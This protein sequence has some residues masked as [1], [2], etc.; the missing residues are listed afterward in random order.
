MLPMHGR[1]QRTQL[2]LT[3]QVPKW[4]TDTT[5]CHYPDSD[6]ITAIIGHRATHANT[7]PRHGLL[8]AL[9]QATVIKQREVLHT[10]ETAR[11][12]R[13]QLLHTAMTARALI[14]YLPSITH[15]SEALLP[16]LFMVQ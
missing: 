14:I 4:K 1:H 3:M 6:H 12:L 5:S 11:V 2:L 7:Q 13:E 9:L 8:T 10:S 16:L 15:P